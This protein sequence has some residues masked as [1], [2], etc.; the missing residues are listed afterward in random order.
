MHRPTTPRQ[1][2]FALLLA[3]PLTCCGSDAES[4][5]S[6][7]DGLKAG[8][9]VFVSTK[10]GGQVTLEQTYRV[11]SVDRRGNLSATP[12]SD[13]GAL[14][15]VLLLESQTAGDAPVPLVERQ[16]LYR[17]LWTAMGDSHPSASGPELAAE[18]A[19]LDRSIE[20][21]HQDIGGSGLPV[22]NYVSFYEALDAHLTH[23]DAEGELDSFLEH[24]GTTPAAFLGMLRDHGI[25]WTALLAHMAARGTSFVGLYDG[26][27]RSN[28]P[29]G[30][31]L[32]AYMTD[33][34]SLGE[35]G[36]GPLD[37]AKFAWD[38]I[39]DNRPQTALENAYTSVLSSRDG[40]YEHY[41]NARSGESEE[42]QVEA[43]NILGITLARVH[44]NLS[45]YY[46]AVN[47]AIGGHWLPSVTFSVD[48]AYALWGYNINANA[49][50]TSASNVGPADAPVPEIKVVAKVQI[51]SLLQNMT[52]SRDFI[53]N[54]TT[55][56]SK[57]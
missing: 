2:S 25:G 54:G 6:P 44:L 38:V 9:P 27:A 26:Y 11:Y 10:V 31:Y 29:L 12:A 55:G 49:V 21:L 41:G 3:L 50:I 19:D 15:H 22:K 48:D 13:D 33:S 45:G 40:N 46:D 52:V 8:D 42:W 37:V 51:S 5:G 39:Q 20:E 18:I 47:A 30:D 14:G 53:A 16:N 24:A 35:G 1:T 36:G 57:K 4:P 7:S 28:L 17:D 56:F 23:S 34:V 43:T 32:D